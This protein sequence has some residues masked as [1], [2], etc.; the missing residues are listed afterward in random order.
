MYT[1]TKVRTYKRHD[2]YYILHDTYILQCW[3]DEMY[4]EIMHA[5]N[6][7]LEL[8]KTRGATAPTRTT[9]CCHLQVRTRQHVKTMQPPKHEHTQFHSGMGTQTHCALIFLSFNPS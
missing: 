4:K 1:M 5:I 2:I 8:K 3:R 7:Y 6:K 9:C